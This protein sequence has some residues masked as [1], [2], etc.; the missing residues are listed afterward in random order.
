[1]RDGGL[2]IA[3]LIDGLGWGGAEAL[4]VDFALGARAIGVEVVVGYLEDKDGSPMAARLRAHGVPVELLG[5]DRMLQR[6]A[7]GRVR[8]WLRAVGP[9][10]L[11][12]HLGYSDLLGVLAARPL[13]VPAVCTIHVMSSRDRGAGRDGVKSALFA[14]ARRRGTARVVAV[15]DQA[16]AA[17]LAAG[18]DR[19]SHVVTVHNGVV[20]DVSAGAGRRVRAEL[21]I[22]AGDVVL[23]Q[24]AVL[25]A[26]KGHDEAVAAVASLARAGR[27]VRLLVAGDGPE[28]AR[29]GALAAAAGP[30]VDVLGHRDDVAALLDA[31]DV[32]VHPTA[33]DAFPTA[34]LEAARAAVP[35]VATAVG[36][37]PEIVRDGVTGLLLPAPVDEEDLGAALRAL[38]DDPERRA[39]MGAAARRVYEEEFTAQRW[40]ERLRSVYEDALRH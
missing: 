20:D 32:L 11:H 25:R 26:G 22:D 30:C 38:V 28:R 21:G 6:D 33:A 7:V 3:A 37:V 4:L 29:I 15:S 10:V 31:A 40:A 2:R 17:Y 1:M 16:R 13:G 5:V 35:V 27:P 24:L 23:L 18:R 8:R 36:G 19:P 9:D 12:T 34:L 39:G 14:L